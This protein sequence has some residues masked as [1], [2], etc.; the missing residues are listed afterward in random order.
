MTEQDV[1]GNLMALLG[2]IDT[3]DTDTAAEAAMALL[4]GFLLTQV[5]IV[6]ALEDIRMWG[7]GQSVPPED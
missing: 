3:D 4:E 1:R 6:E 7:V 5:R 2:A